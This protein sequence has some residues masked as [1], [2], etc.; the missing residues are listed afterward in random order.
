M[1]KRQAHP[2]ATS[3]LALKVM[4]TALAM[5]MTLTGVTFHLA[6]QNGQA[7]IFVDFHAFYAA[8]TL[9]LEGRAGDAYRMATM[10]V[11]QQQM[12]GHETF[13]PWTYP[14][15]FTL[16]VA[17]LAALPLGLGYAL[18]TGISLAAYLL[19]LRRIAGDWLPGVVLVLLPVLVLGV[20]TGQN[21]FLTGALTGWFVLALL[22]CK[23]RAGLP[24]GLMIIK[25]H[26]A[27][28]IA[29]LT[30]AQ[31]RWQAVGIAAVV[32]LA[33]LLVPTLVFG[34]PIWNAFAD[35]VRESG[36]LLAEGRYPMHRMTSP[37]AFALG[38]DAAPELAFA[39]QG[40]S[41]LSAIGLL[42]L[43]WHRRL[44][45]RLLAACACTA[46]LFVSPYA[47]D[48][49]LTLLGVALALVLPD[50]LQRT[51]WAEQAAMLMLAWAATGYGLI[52]ALLGNGE[53]VRVAQQ[54]LALMAPLLLVLIG[55]AAMA[56]RRRLLTR[57]DIAAAGLG[58][59]DPVP[60]GALGTVSAAS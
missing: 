3:P 7:G 13:M 24:L 30:L 6:S 50:L 16:F 59:V 12:A 56:M 36:A 21:G 43:A 57:P 22:A 55:W 29:L 17:G 15:P 60:V 49:D 48:Y 11:V 25:P 20:I 58:A 28:G 26:L 8:G 18:F 39:V 53:A 34:L 52:A 42:G 32:V 41:A 27:A 23:P 45:P 19:V 46:T 31:R 35:G 10:E 37:Y 9:A 4:L 54:P 51:G 1:I 33:A 5:L 47:Y 40:V 38:L 2:L 44:P 14:P